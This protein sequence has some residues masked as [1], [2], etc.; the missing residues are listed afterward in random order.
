MCFDREDS[1]RTANAGALIPWRSQDS[2]PSL[3]NAIRQPGP[4]TPE[5]PSDQQGFARGHVHC[6]EIYRLFAE[7]QPC[8]LVATADARPGRARFSAGRRAPATISAAPFDQNRGDS[9]LTRADPGEELGLEARGRT[10]SRALSDD[11]PASGGP[12]GGWKQ[13]QQRPR[14][15]LTPI[16]SERPPRRSAGN[17]QP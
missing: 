14:R 3:P 4:G 9:A 1:E 11:A 8:H 17:P 15:R 6:L 16:G 13:D 2:E 12:V 10:R 7:M 5:P